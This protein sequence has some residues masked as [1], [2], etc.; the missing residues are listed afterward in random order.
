MNKFI[1]LIMS[2]RLLVKKILS[3]S[4]SKLL[5]IVWFKMQHRLFILV[6][7]FRLKILASDSIYKYN[8][9]L[10]YYSHNQELFDV[11]YKF[12]NKS[13][14]VINVANDILENK[15]NLLGEKYTIAEKDWL[16][17]PVSKKELERETF[18]IDSK[19]EEKKYGDVKF[20]MELNKMGFLVSLAHAYYLSSDEKYIKKM[21]DYLEGWI[22]TV[23]YEKSIVNKSMLDISFRCL[24]L[25]Q[26]TLLCFN[27]NFFKAMVFPVISGILIASE[28]QIR[29]FSTPR[30]TKFSTG[31]NHTIG[32]MSGLII[33]QLW[34]EQFTS[35]TYQRYYRKQFYY[36]N[37]SL[38]N[39]IT[40]KG[41]YLEQSSHY[42]KLVAEFLV[43]LDISISAIGKKIPDDIYHK[44]YLIKL[45][46]YI[47]TISYNG[48]LPNFGDNDGAKVLYPFYEN[49]YSVSH[50]LMYY[51]YINPDANDKNALICTES[52]QFAWQSKDKKKTFVFI[53][54]GK[55]SFL[56]VGSGSHAHNDILSLILSAN[57]KPIFIDF[58]TYF[59]NSGIEILNNDRK[60]SNHNT[61]SF[62]GVEQA[63]L[64]GKWMYGSYPQ[65][66]FVGDSISKNDTSFTF[67]GSCTYSGR[68][69]NRNIKYASSELEIIDQIKCEKDDKVK[70]NFLLSPD[71]KAIKDSTNTISLY[72][73][74][75]KIALI[76]FP[77][78]INLDIVESVYHPS[79][80]IEKKTKKITGQSTITGNQ[81]IITLVYIL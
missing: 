5:Y 42:S 4:F 27:N 37:R 67:K 70:I 59:Y 20:V 75:N 6:E 30:W 18:F 23:S 25:I 80:G 10:N 49:N 79:Y 2:K 73:E 35:K 48:T 76:Q 24:N 60:T 69:H 12:C 36:L 39:I 31:A 38:E 55:H 74:K 22:E 26:I 66:H 11:F 40:S 21:N 64:A 28:R 7:K 9:S 68:T 61:I 62:D 72:R 77:G 81:K 47:T 58:G 17:D 63:L 44:E 34:L 78:T 53:R 16:T 19:I 14:E 8:G 50:L 15:I 46:Q 57:Y 65:S 51:E 43:M 71:I 41:V 45:L 52:G 33:T 3:V 1:A 32:E 54:S 13:N 56:P 29:K